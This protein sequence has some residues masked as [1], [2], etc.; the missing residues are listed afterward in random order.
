M[1]ATRP[2]SFSWAVTTDKGLRRTSNE[3]SHC[4]RSDIGLFVVADGMG[5]HVA[6][7]VAS[8][9]AVDAIQAFISRHRQ[10]RQEP[11]LALSV[12][13]E[14]QPRSQSPEGRIPSGE[15]QDRFG[16]RRGQRSARHGHDGFCTPRRRLVGLRRPRRRQPGLPAPQGSARPADTRSLVGRGAG[17]CRH[18]ER[19][20]RATASVAQR[21]H[22]RAVRRRGSRRSTSPRWSRRRAIATCSARTGCSRSSPIRRLP[23]FSATPSARS[24]RS[25]KLSSLPPM[26]AAVRTTSPRSCSRSMLHNL[27][28]LTRY[29]GLIQSLVA[30]ELKARYRGSVLGFFWSFINPLLLLLV[31]SFVFKYV[32][33]GGARP[34][35][36]ALRALHVLRHPAVDVVLVV[37]RRIVWRADLRRQP[38]QE[39]AVPSRDPA[40]RD[41]AGEHDP[42]LL[43]ADHPGR[44]PR[45]LSAPAQLERARALSR[46]G[47]RAAGPDARVRAAPV[48]AHRA[49]SETSAT[50]CRTC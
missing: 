47:R 11:H 35:G 25:A 32:M 49:F 5:G 21:R 7:E 17:A 37:A 14:H 3:D 6:G 43:R 36:R 16:D 46:C 8:R 33:T 41:R 28:R 31:Y 10:R 18:D 13:T 38:D 40:D 26:P 1:S 24:R 4:E 9:E 30:R 2:L 20:G 44:V 48:S 39:S 15:S 23:R 22:T 50:S 34:R 19:V 12:R 42:L 29:R 27:V 45:L